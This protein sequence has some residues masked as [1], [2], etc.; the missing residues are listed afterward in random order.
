MTDPALALRATSDALLADI[1]RLAELERAKRI[2]AP[3]D[4]QLVEMSTEIELL[5][6]RVLERTA[7][8]RL[9]S[10]D[11]EALVRLDVPPAPS[12]SIEATEPLTRS[13]ST[14][15]VSP[16]PALEA[17][18][19]REIH[20]ILDDWREAERRAG[21]A[22]PGSPEAEVA[23]IDAE[24]LKAEYQRAFRAAQSKG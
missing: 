11:A 12:Q 21:E 8:E 2:L 18:V 9:L 15:L 14:S 24:R 19:S 17:G 7:E 23:R 10:E 16:A 3:G 6:N 4:P 22:L 20:V 13:A 5:A 1:G